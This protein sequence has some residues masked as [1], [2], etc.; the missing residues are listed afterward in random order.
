MNKIGE[1]RFAEELRLFEINRGREAVIEWLRTHPREVARVLAGMKVL[2]YWHPVSKFGWE[3]SVWGSDDDSPCAL[4]EIDGVWWDANRPV[5][6]DGF[7]VDE[8]GFRGRSWPSR[9][10]AERVLDEEMI[11]RGW[12]LVPGDDE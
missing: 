12:V 8:H 2:G 3:R 11:A 4:Y 9:E 7:E 1:E 10:E 6:G 5:P